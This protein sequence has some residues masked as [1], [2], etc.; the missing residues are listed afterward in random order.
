M[1]D[2]GHDG[3]GEST[4]PTAS[5]AIPIIWRRSRDNAM[6]QAPSINSG[7]RKMTST[8]SGSTDIAGSPGTKASKA[9]P[10]SSATDGGSPS[11]WAA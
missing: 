2:N 8:S 7:G 4:A 3:A 11:L 6:D 9:P 5:E 1:D 10:V